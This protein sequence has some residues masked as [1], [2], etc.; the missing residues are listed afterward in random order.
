M[1]DQGASCDGMRTLREWFDAGLIGDITKVYNWTN[2]PVW[3]QGIPWPKE[4]R[5]F[6][7]N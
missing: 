1:G 6:Q 7:K 2:R 3:P 4:N 5:P